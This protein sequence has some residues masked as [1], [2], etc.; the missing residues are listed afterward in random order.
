ML[1]HKPLGIVACAVEQDT[2]MLKVRSQ[3]FLPF[4]FLGP[5]LQ[6][7]EVPRLGDQIGATAAGLC[8]SH[9]NT[10]SEPRLQPIPQLPTKLDP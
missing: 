5:R 4:V 3:V 9:G 2:N 10:G 7:R 8:C 6:H 1:Y